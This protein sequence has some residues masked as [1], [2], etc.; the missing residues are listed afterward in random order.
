MIMGGCA[1]ESELDRTRRL[2][3]DGDSAVQF[4]LGNLYREG[5]GVS[6]DYEEAV[7]WYRK[8]AEQGNAS[9]QFNLGTSYYNGEGVSQDYKEAYAW[10]S[11][12][13]ANGEELAEKYFAIV[14]KKMTKD[15]IADAQSLSTEIYNRIEANRKD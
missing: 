5:E 8:S 14:S 11:V 2:A 4:K 7:K 9:A 13:K 1:E 6:Q 10:W 3:S 15:Q 12:A